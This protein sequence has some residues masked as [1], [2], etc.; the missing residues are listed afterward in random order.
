MVPLRD[1][2]DDYYEFD[3]KNYCLVGRRLHRRYS[4]GDKVRIKVARANLDRRQLDFTLV[5]DDNHA[6][7]APETAKAGYGKPH[8][9]PGKKKHRK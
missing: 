9:S 6:I 5:S 4:I 1:L 3:E 8:P 7:P 2:L